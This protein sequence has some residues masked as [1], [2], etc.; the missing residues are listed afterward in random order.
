MKNIVYIVFIAIISGF[1][2]CSQPE[3]I[4][5]DYVVPNGLIYPGQAQ[6]PVAKSGDERIEISWYRG[7]DP[8]VDKAKIFW[9]NYTD[10]VEV[11]IAPGVD[12]IIRII[13]PIAENTYS[14]M[15]HTY[16]TD[17]NKSIP[18]E[19]IGT[20][21][22]QN[23]KSRLTNR[24]L[25]STYYDG[26]DLTLNWGTATGIE[27]VSLSWTNLDDG[28]A[29][30][31]AI[32]PSEMVSII[33][34]FDVDRPLS[35]STTYRPDSTSIDIFHA[36][37]IE[38]M[39]DP[40]IPIPKD[41][42]VE[43]FLSEDILPVN[44]SYPLQKMWDGVMNTG[45]NFFHSVDA[46]GT[47]PCTFTWDLGLQA[48][49][50][51]MKMWP[52]TDNG[53]DRWNRSQVKQFEIYGSL[54]EPDPDESMDGWSLLGTFDYEIPSGSAGSTSATTQDI[55]FARA[56]I[57][58]VFPAPS[59]TVRYIRFKALS[60]FITEDEIDKGEYDRVIISE[61]SFWG[62]LVR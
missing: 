16:D 46:A 8:K 22:G 48:I 38:I 30:T 18:V 42:W 36:P 25:R 55:E 43:Y 50:S 29:K 51:R 53:S 47:F 31:V 32:E 23:Y 15:I 59:I 6:N 41:T 35:Y 17:G 1:S 3:D 4:Y 45:G 57:D 5:K 2:S 61:I 40:V 21:Y 54:E 24:L 58:F 7:T 52:R 26:R 11:S 14:F 12:T 49:L 33:P 10:S 27:G 56:G 34:D 28:T 37:S 39:I 9:N 60:T 13:A 19:V 44:S 20:V 62:R